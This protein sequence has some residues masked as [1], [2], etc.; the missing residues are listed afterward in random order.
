[1]TFRNAFTVYKYTYKVSLPGI[2]RLVQAN[3]SVTA[4]DVISAQY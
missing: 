1:M 4:C 2:S 3:A